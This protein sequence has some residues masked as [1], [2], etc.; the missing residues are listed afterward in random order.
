MNTLKSIF[1]FVIV[2]S[3]IYLGYKGLKSAIASDSTQK[4]IGQTYAVIV[5]VSDYQYLKS[6]PSVVLPSDPNSYD[7][8][9]C[10]DDANLFYDF[11]RSP[12]GG[13]VPSEN[14]ARLLD[15]QATKANIIAQMRSLFSKSTP[16]DRVIFYFTGHGTYQVLCPHDMDSDASS[17]LE[18]N[19]IA[20]AFRECRAKDRF[21]IAD[22]CNT[23]SMKVHSDTHG[24]PAN[25]SPTDK[26]IVAFMASKANQS[27]RENQRIGHGY[28][29][30]YL[31]KGARGEADRD[32]NGVVTIKELY[33][34][35]RANVMNITGAKVTQKMEKDYQTPVIFG[36]FSDS[37]PFSY[38]VATQ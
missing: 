15:S 29:T 20:G 6:R 38:S 30:Y 17:L 14:I 10:D 5:G 9:Y 37:L 4:E 31:D 23:G 8:E 18:Y 11:L 26:N 3:G 33:G 12:Q 32:K 21:F 7:L 2:A 19:A 25:T 35:V 34:F 24:S 28:F 36:K 16:N 13:S 1:I 22:A 27:S